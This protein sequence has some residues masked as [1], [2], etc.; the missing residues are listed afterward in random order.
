MLLIFAHPRFFSRKVKPVQNGQNV[1]CLKIMNL[2][3]VEPNVWMLAATIETGKFCLIMNKV[4]RF[5]KIY[6]E[7]SV[8]ER[9]FFN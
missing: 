2:H 1:R 4:L 7:S 6:D 5:I 9:K 3:Y 8:K